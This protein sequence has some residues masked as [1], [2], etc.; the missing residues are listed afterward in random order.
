MD[1]VILVEFYSGI[2]KGR[3]HLLT[4]IGFNDQQKEN[5]FVWSDGSTGEVYTLHI[6]IE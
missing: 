6:C 2:I 1:V 5:I 3:E 4:W